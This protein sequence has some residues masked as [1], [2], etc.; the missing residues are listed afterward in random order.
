MTIKVGINGFGRI[1]R[2]ILRRIL[3]SGESDIAVVYINDPMPSDVLAHLLEFDSL[4]GRLA[5]PLC[6]QD[7]R[8]L[9]DDTSIALSHERA[10]EKLPWQEVDIAL[11]CSGRFLTPAEAAR[12]FSNGSSRV[13]LSAPGKEKMK[14]VVYGVNHMSIEPTDRLVSN[15]SCTTNCLAP[16]AKILH[17]A[18]TIERGM[19][20]TVHSYT[21]TQNTHDGPHSDLYRARAAALSMIPTTTGAADILGEVLPELAGRISGHA[22]R[23][24]TPN[25]SCI[26]LVVDLSCEVTVDDINALCVSA[27]SGPYR[28]IVDTTDR[29]LVSTDFR[30]NPNSAIIACDQT[31][32][33]GK[34]ARILAWYDNEWGF[35]NRMI[36]VVR[37]MGAQRL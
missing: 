19:M 16:V 30:Q 32:I 31:R 13:L 6:L 33:Q 18:F 2:S 4:H 36:D 35:A 1:G 12:H 28:G 5:H 27:A 10:P 26:D 8:L 11:E 34:M 25:V 37:M 23:V 3:D 21:S 29:K 17:D 15:A 22:I 9:I 7:G 24:P 14:T 20:T